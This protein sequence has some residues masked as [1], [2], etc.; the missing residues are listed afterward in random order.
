MPFGISISSWQQSAGNA[1]TI[2]TEFND[3]VSFQLHQFSC[4]PYIPV[5]SV[6]LLFDM[7]VSHNNRE[8]KS[9]WSIFSIRGFCGYIS[10][11]CKQFCD[12]TRRQRNDMNF[13]P[14]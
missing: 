10:V 4:K 6:V 9:F 7:H 2:K 1:A 3:I 5:L 12:V 13:D 11:N 8:M 14:K